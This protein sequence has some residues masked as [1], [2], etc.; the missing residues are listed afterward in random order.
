MSITAEEWAREH[1]PDAS[2]VSMLRWV[3]PR[4]TKAGIIATTAASVILGLI[5][6]VALGLVYPIIGI[7]TGID[8]TVGPISLLWGFLG[9]PNSVTFGIT[10]SA[11]LIGTFAIKDALTI[12][13]YTWQTKFIALEQANLSEK[14]LTQIMHSS[15]VEY[16]QSSKGF[17]LHIIQT[18]VG[19]SFNKVI[20]GLM[21]VVV[22]VFSTLAI[23]SV[24]VITSP[25]PALVLAVYM[26][27]AGSLYNRFIKPIGL[28]AG[29]RMAKHQK[30]TNEASLQALS[31]FKETKL[32]H[33]AQYFIDQYADHN[34]KQAL[35]GRTANLVSLSTKYILEIFLILA[36]GAFLIFTFATENIA[37]SVASLALLVAAAFR[38]LP[39]AAGTLSNLNQIRSGR[40]SLKQLYWQI[41]Y[42][43]MFDDRPQKLDEAGSI[44]FRSELKLR[45]L[46]VRYPG[47][48]HDVLSDIN[49]SI[50][51]GSSL[52]LVGSS[53][54][55]KTTLADT[56]L[57]LI[58]PRAGLIESDRT[59]I[60]DDLTGWQK[61]CAMVSQ[62]IYIVDGTIAD[63]V[64]FDE[65]RENYNEEHIRKALHAAQLIDLVNDS[66]EGIHTRTGENGSRLSGGQRQ[67]LGIA[68]AIYRDPKLLVFDE[69]TS[70]LDNVTEQKI[71]EVID[72]LKGSIT[73]IVIAHRLSTVKN[74]DK[75]AFL[76]EGQITGVGT[77]GQL[78]DSH[79]GF[80]ELVRL[81]AL[82]VE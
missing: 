39:L 35:A 69:A 59:N 28:S 15:L 29:D 12:A 3:L 27:V 41:R 23:L 13:F 75:I 67:R 53:G 46:S 48:D 38:L 66:P 36:L 77:F 32:R 16:R 63:N 81:G 78:Y 22:A 8:Y 73:T 6:S 42:G 62:E 34:E 20:N 5:E 56:I 64:V 57:G 71:T 37:N 4:S 50:P 74:A 44:D 14:L 24:V 33:T 82:G 7:A 60:Q 11:I 49:L 19:N 2:L 47:A 18:T 70:A 30:A 21:G 54:S 43:S 76:E 55:G 72:S 25:I 40:Y 80:A 52:A 17:A 65:P 61:K 51:F 9:K 79:A 68:R 10:L 26:I 1:D 45:Q 58:Q 31:A